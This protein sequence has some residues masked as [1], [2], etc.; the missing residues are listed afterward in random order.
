MCGDGTLLQDDEKKDKEDEKME[1]EEGEKEKQDKEKLE[2]EP[3]ANFQI[4]NNPARVMKA[5]VN[6]WIRKCDQVKLHS[7][8]LIDFIFTFHF[9]GIYYVYHLVC[10]IYQIFW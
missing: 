9:N 1:T 2:K 5:Q 10:C 7:K 8:D 3:E 4:L 6:I